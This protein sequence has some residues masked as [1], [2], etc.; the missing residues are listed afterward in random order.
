[1]KCYFGDC[2]MLLYKE[3]LGSVL[4]VNT[5]L[6][7]MSRELLFEIGSRKA[8]MF[9]TLCMNSGVLSP[10]QEYSFNIL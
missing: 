6:L 9:S 5:C 10:V 7:A 4:E 1:M 2:N 8:F 3:A